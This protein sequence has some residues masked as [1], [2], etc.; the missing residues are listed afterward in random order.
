MRH[1]HYP[2]YANIPLSLPVYTFVPTAG[3]DKPG[4]G[5]L[6]TPECPR[7]R[8]AKTQI[9]ARM[10]NSRGC[11]INFIRT[12][13]YADAFSSFCCHIAA[14]SRR[15]AIRNRADIPLSDIGR[16][17]SLI[18]TVRILM[19]PDILCPAQVIP[20]GFK[21]T[22]S[23]GTG[24]RT[25]RDCSWL[26]RQSKTSGPRLVV[27]RDK[28]NL[29]GIFVAVACRG[30]HTSFPARQAYLPSRYI[31]SDIAITRHDWFLPRSLVD[32]VSLRA[33]SKFRDAEI[34]APNR[35][36]EH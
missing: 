27:R 32:F 16:S 15:E 33:N 13:N 23:A 31:G 4:S 19:D 11:P 10:M 1:C 3:D 20:V 29:R 28:V 18:C 34:A 17:E 6:P 2:I 25:T 26:H 8:I 24:A 12:F 36:S 22:A 30:H 9:S 14:V 21:G 7:L 35:D 5:G